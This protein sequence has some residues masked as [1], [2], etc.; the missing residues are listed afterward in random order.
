MSFETK[1]FYITRGDQLRIPLHLKVA[2]TDLKRELGLMNVYF[3]N[4][5][6]GV[7]FNFTSTNDW[8]FWMKNTY[9]PLDILFID[10]NG[11]II[12]IKQGKPLDLTNIS[13]DNGLSKYAIELLKGTCEK[14]GIQVGDT[15]N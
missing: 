15:I 3:L 7:F 5:R 6:E 13:C 9:I 14:Y 11:K 1:N 4:D 2:D 12:C 8:K 10:N